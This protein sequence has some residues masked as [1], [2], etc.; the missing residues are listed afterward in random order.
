MVFITTWR[1]MYFTFNSLTITPM[2][3]DYQKTPCRMY[4]LSVI[5]T[6]SCFINFSTSILVPTAFQLSNM[7]GHTQDVVTLWKYLNSTMVI[8]I[9]FLSDLKCLY[10][11]ITFAV[12]ISR[13]NCRPLIPLHYLL[14]KFYPIGVDCL[15][16]IFTVN[17]D[18]SWGV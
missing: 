4:Q 17:S 7:K 13:Q 14:V 10:F 1:T 2:C 11:H 16:V 9:N 12:I 15:I 6:P 18:Q 8:W 3:Q 5:I